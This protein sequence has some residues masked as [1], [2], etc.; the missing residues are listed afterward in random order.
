MS[1]PWPRRVL[2]LVEQATDD[3]VVTVPMLGGS[4]SLYRVQQTFGVPL[5]I[6]PI[7]I[8]PIIIVPVVNHDNHQ[9]APNKNLRLSHLWRGIE[10]YAAPLAHLGAKEFAGQP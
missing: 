1:E 7:I 9:H 5:I 4:L 10:I 6:V 3:P 2:D 8:V